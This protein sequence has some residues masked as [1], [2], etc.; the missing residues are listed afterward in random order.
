AGHLLAA[1]HA[2]I[3][4]SVLPT[5]PAAAVA[6]PRVHR[7]YADIARPRTEAELLARVEELAQVLWRVAEGH[8]RHDEPLRRALAFYE[9]GSRLSMAGGFTAA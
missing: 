6:W 2:R 1:A 3:V 7:T 8:P 4:F 5:L 9:A